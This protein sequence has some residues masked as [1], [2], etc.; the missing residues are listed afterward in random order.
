MPAHY[1]SPL[2]EAKIWDLVNFV[3]ALPYEPELL[4]DAPAAAAGHGGRLERGRPVTVERSGLETGRMSRVS[5]S[6]DVHRRATEV[7]SADCS[8]LRTP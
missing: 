2:N 3:L 5:R 7:E 6:D 4:K 1:P 8:S